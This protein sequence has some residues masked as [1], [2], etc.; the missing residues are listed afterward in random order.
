MTNGQTNGDDE[1]L[2]LAMGGGVILGLIAALAVVMWIIR[3]VL[4]G[5]TVGNAFLIVCL[6]GFMVWLIFEGIR[7]FFTGIKA[8]I[9]WWLLVAGIAALFFVWLFGV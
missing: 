9:R 5:T 4:F 8:E 3:Y 7:W 6:L 2:G 1:A